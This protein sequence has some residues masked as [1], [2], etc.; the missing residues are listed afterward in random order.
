MNARIW[1]IVVL[2][3]GLAAWAWL[4]FWWRSHPVLAMAGVA[5]LACGAGLQLGVQM[6][7]MR[8]ACR[9]RGLAVPAGRTLLKAWWTE[10]RLSVY[11]FGW[12]IPF[13]AQAQPDRLHS[14]QVALVLVHGYFCNRAVWASWMR[15]LKAL[16][17]G[18][19]AVTLEPAQGDS[20]DA[21]VKSLDG[22]AREVVARTGRAP[23]IVAH[24][25]GG[26]VVRA[27]L[28]ALPAE[29][30]RRLA[31]HVVTVATPHHG[32]W[33]ARFAYCLP[34]LDMR[35]HSPW[36]QRLGPPGPDVAFSCWCS[37]SDNIVFPPDL[38][39]LA[40]SEVHVVDDAAHMQL[41][42]DARVWAYCLALRER[43]QGA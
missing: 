13:R 29:E 36:L 23:L 26:L 39:Q 33:L 18:C 42:H 11:L 34:A 24:S 22:C 41:L 30:R 8:S 7:L 12:R 16:G 15:K 21:M 6:L 10:W 20:A 40:G 27:W 43:L 19:A 5:V 37:R 32:T 4:A 35:E 3:S 38:A 9:A 28:K 31:A 14:G 1:R 17:I 2:G 25:L